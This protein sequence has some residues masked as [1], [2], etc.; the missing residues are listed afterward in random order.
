MKKFL[1][2]IAFLGLLAVNATAQNSNE[3]ENQETGGLS[4]FL[5][6]VLQEQHAQTVSHRQGVAV[7]F[8]STVHG[9]FDGAQVSFINT[10][11]NDAKG[12]QVGF[13]NTTRGSYNGGQVGFI[14]SVTSSVR[15]AQVGYVNTAAG[16]VNG[17]QVGFVNT[18]I[19]EV[20]GAQVGFVNT[21]T[22]DVDGFQVGFVN[23]T[24]GEVS[25]AQVGFVNTATKD[26]DG[27]QVGFVNTA[28]GDCNAQIGFVNVATGDVNGQVG[29]VNITAG[30]VDAQIGFVNTARKLNG[31]QLGFVNFADTIE[32]G[33][34]IGFLS[35]V[36]QGG[37][38]AVEVGISEFHLVNVGFKLGVERFYTTFSIS[39]NPFEDYRSKSFA[40]GFGFGTIVPINDSF[41]FN[42]EII[43]STSWSRNTRNLTSFVPH[44]GYNLGNH[45]SVTLAP[46]VTWS[47]SP[48]NMD[49]LEP[50][51]YVANFEIDDRNAIVVGARLNLRVR[52]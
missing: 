40:T 41:F 24:I 22:K 49:L 33:V 48:R 43:G 50:I 36:R 35:I 6:Q 25:G 51:F 27:L 47:R 13:I 9:T 1:F 10:I 8:I 7:G 29:F 12:A 11:T 28:V 21:A 39:Y 37:F 16:D 46:S 5:S 4:D 19:G 18:A 38:R 3:T 20:S 44:F 26:V 14:N 42:P 17:A 23:T 52:F 34:S 2:T 31:L 15:G 32:N 30:E 45:F